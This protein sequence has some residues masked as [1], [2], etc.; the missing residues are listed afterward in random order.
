[1]IMNIFR[2]HVFNFMGGRTSVKK[3]ILLLCHQLLS[4]WTFVNTDVLSSFVKL[5]CRPGIGLG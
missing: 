1:M 2:R 3:L 4:I 5:V